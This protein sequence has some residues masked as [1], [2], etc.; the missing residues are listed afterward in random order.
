MELS[1]EMRFRGPGC[2]E[3][4]GCWRGGAERIPAGITSV[5]VFVSTLRSS[6]AFGWRGCGGRGKIAYLL[7]IR[8]S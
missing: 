1:R 8:I 6:E 7:L 2:A 3:G 5:H 4:G